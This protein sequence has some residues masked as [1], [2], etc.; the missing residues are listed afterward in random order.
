MKPPV[1]PFAFALA[2]FG[3]LG[4]R[5]GS[6]EPVTV[7]AEADTTVSMSIRLDRHDS[8]DYVPAPDTYLRTRS[9]EPG[10]SY[11]APPVAAIR[12]LY[13]ISPDL[14]LDAI[15]VGYCESGWNPEAAIIDIDGL[16]REGAFMVGAIWHGPVP[17]DLVGQALQFERI[18]N[19][20]GLWPFTTR[21]GCD[22]WA[23]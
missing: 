13:A 3:L 18:V 15:R 9:L 8:P 1:L 5:G 2:A 20:H 23:R 22:R 7:E 17:A 12:A 21:D 19:E 10:E 11:K 4:M 14:E 6:A 16:P